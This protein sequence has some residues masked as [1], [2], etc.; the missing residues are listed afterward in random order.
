MPAS[1]HRALQL[2]LAVA[3][4]QLGVWHWDRGAGTV[5][6]SAE[7]E[8][9]AGMSP[10]T[11]GGTFEH[12]LA[13]VHPDD[14]DAV[15]AAIEAGMDRGSFVV[16]HRF[17]HPDGR[18]VWVEGR[19]SV[20]PGEGG[21]AAGMVGVAIDVTHRVHHRHQLEAEQ[22]ILRALNRISLQ[23]NREHEG[24]RLAQTI[25]EVT[26]EAC[27]TGSAALLQ[28]P[29]ILHP[30]AVV[31]STGG[32]DVDPVAA[33][34]AVGEEMRQHGP[35]AVGV[36]RAG[37]I[38]AV[39]VGSTLDLNLLLVVADDAPDPERAER[40]LAGIGAHAGT[41][42]E[43]ARL[44]EVARRELAA[45]N[46]ALA[47][48]DEVMRQ[49]QRSLLPPALPDIPGL[50]IAA[51]YLPMTEGIGGDFYD[52]FP[53]AE[54]TWGVVLG[55]VC[56][57]GPA[58]AG[59]TALAR[60]TLR[61][62]AV[63]EHRPEESVRILNQ[64]MVDRGTDDR[65]FCTLIDARLHQRAAAVRIVAG[66]AGHPPLLVLRAD[67]TLERHGPTGHLV[68]MFD[69]IVT[70]ELE[71]EL[72]PGDLCVL[73]TD[74]ATD[75]RRDG[76]EFGDDRLADV[77]HGCRAMSAAAVVRSIEVA[78]VDFQRGQISDDLAVVAIRVPG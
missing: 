59:I 16:E 48:R 13:A 74:G 37:G 43:N 54:G 52:V 45:R 39:P 68:G 51:G 1:D 67:G 8:R 18:V 4:G 25:V 29:S 22:P 27:G 56:G 2:E 66:V 17:R 20:R 30:W 14:R 12:Y 71:V 5:E 23:L 64:A 24:D 26:A 10:G 78:V 19:G 32:S 62:A 7:M 57:K 3:A 33:A 36:T 46:A 15:L 58:A 60:H 35:S 21:D 34:G 28:R 63:A 31:G 69:E 49:L 65:T 42:L 72:G 40:L 73:H 11:F 44:H 77:V 61:A 38:L 6:W 41:A 76:T 75:V 70:G 53:L 47:E 55:D 50:D 9:L